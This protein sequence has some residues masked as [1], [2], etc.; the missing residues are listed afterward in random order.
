MSPIAFAPAV[1]PDSYQD[2]SSS[3][4]AD[5]RLSETDLLSLDFD[6]SDPEPRRSTSGKRKSANH[7]PRP[8]NAFILFRSA[9][10]RSQRVTSGVE[11]SHST[12]SK[13]IGMTWQ[14]LS[15]EERQKWHAKAKLA[16]EDHKRRYPQ[17][18]FK[19]IHHRLRGANLGRRKLR[20]VGPK[21]QKRCEKIAELL[22]SG[23]KGEE[24]EVEIR[25]FDK[26]H[27]P[28]IV[29]RFEEP[30]TASSFSASSRGS[31]P[32]SRRST[33]PSSQGRPSPA[34]PTPPPI[35]Q[36]EPSVAA[37]TAV[38]IAPVLSFDS[39][40]LFHSTAHSF[41]SRFQLIVRPGNS[42]DP[43]QSYS[44]QEIDN[45]TFSV[46]PPS[47][48][49]MVRRDLAPVIGGD[50]VGGYGDVGRSPSLF[51]YDEWVAPR[52]PTSPGS[53]STP[54]VV[55][56]EANHLSFADQADPQFGDG[57][58]TSCTNFASDF[59][60]G[61][62]Q[63][64]DCSRH[65]PSYTIP[66]YAS[67]PQTYAAYPSQL[68]VQQT[69]HGVKRT[70]SLSPCFRTDGSASGG[71]HVRSNPMAREELDFSMFMASFDSSYPL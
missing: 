46:Q 14:Q 60:S 23:K 22:A 4:S 39:D 19:P 61:K 38:R 12:L 56:D 44:L 42:R 59:D 5:Y 27:V 17:Y 24:L 3:L 69:N 71:C 70:A 34:I 10:I 13:I 62:Y 25:E 65:F 15:N 58:A 64:A 49:A 57:H 45:F 11:S 2:P 28:E 53:L 8:P 48:T 36:L 26:H 29:T 54:P 33:T 16:Q 68:T 47:P 63:D 43:E 67:Y 55:V 37:P 41:V 30:I 9:F 52:S 18:S 50:S 35:E 40:A 20:E 51:R 6:D 31:S 1:T 66:N 32:Y 7:I 21:D